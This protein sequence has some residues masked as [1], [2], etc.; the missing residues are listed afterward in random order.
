MVLILKVFILVTAISLLVNMI[1]RYFGESDLVEYVG[2]IERKLNKAQVIVLV[3]LM[4]AF[5][6][7]IL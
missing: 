6:R 5:V 3:I 1:L 2:F 7:F 4:F